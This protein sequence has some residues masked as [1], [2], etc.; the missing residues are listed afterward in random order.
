MGKFLPGYY[1]TDMIIP[2]I[3]KLPAIHSDV[4]KAT[5][6]VHEAITMNNKQ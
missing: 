2:A 6:T 5:I 1:N 4:R 3:I